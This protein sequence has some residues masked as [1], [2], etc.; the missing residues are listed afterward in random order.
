MADAALKEIREA[1]S[2]GGLLPRTIFAVTADHGHV[3]DST[4]KL[5][6]VHGSL[7][8]GVIRVPLAVS[9]PGIPAG[10]RV[11]APVS[12]LDLA[13]TLLELVGETGSPRVP[14]GRSL[15]PLVRGRDPKGELDS[16][17]M[18][19]EYRSPRFH[20]DGVRQRVPDMDLYAMDRDQHALV[21]RGR[22]L[23]SDSRGKWVV[24]DLVADPDEGNSGWGE[25]DEGRAA[26]R[27]LQS[28][29]DQWVAAHPLPAGSQDGASRA[30]SERVLSTIPPN[31]R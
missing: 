15:M 14:D 30:A 24:H 27:E 20:L 1:L 10:K 26:A 7:A 5:A 21:L 9:G 18:V 6:G 28:A 11:A 2:H 13:P 8:E 22:K 17:P 3:F 29:L 16:R 12:T 25:T 23:R 4:A 19:A 31:W